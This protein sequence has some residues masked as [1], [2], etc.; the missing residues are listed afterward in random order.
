MEGKKIMQIQ[1]TAIELKSAEAFCRKC[2]EYR[3]EIEKLF[4]CNFFEC[5]LGRIFFDKAN[6]KIREAEMPKKFKW[7]K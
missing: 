1:F 3:I 2:L 7:T 4:E 6:K 5:E